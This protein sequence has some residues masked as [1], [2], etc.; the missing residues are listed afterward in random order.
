MKTLMMVLSLSLLT[1]TAFV[2]SANAQQSPRERA[3]KECTALDKQQNHDPWDSVSGPMYH[4]RA[5]MAE[6]GQPS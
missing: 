1:A 6:R 5:C 3:I 2:P 4:Y